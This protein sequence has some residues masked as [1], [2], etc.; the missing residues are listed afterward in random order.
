MP[1]SRTLRTALDRVVGQGIVIVRPSC[2]RTAG[3]YVP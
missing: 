1:G 3:F 2:V